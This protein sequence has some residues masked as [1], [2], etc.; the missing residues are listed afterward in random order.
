MNFIGLHSYNYYNEVHADVKVTQP[1]HKRRS[2]QPPPGPSLSRAGRAEPLIWQG[3]LA[4]VDA[5]G[6]VSVSYL[7]GQQPVSWTSTCISQ[8]GIE[9]VNGAGR[10]MN[11]ASSFFPEDCYPKQWQRITTQTMTE[12]AAIDNY[13][14]AATMLGRAFR[15]AR[16]RGVR[17]GV[18]NEVPA[19][20]PR[21]LPTTLA[22]LNAFKAPA[23]HFLTSGF[24]ACEYSTIC[25]WMCG[26]LTGGQRKACASDFQYVYEYGHHN[27]QSWLHTARVPHSIE[28]V[29]WYNGSTTTPGNTL[30]GTSGAVP[31]GYEG[32]NYSRVRH[33]GWIFPP[34]VT[35][36]MLP[37]GANLADMQP[38][39][40]WRQPSTTNRSNCA[41]SADNRT[42]TCVAD[43][44]WVHGKR[45]MPYT[46]WINE[47]TTTQDRCVTA[48]HTAG[49]AFAG[50][51]AGSACFCGDAIPMSKRLPWSSCEAVRCAGNT[52]QPCGAGNVLLVIPVVCRVVPVRT[53][54][55]GD[56]FATSSALLEQQA[57]A[58]GFTVPVATLGL[59]YS[60]RPFRWLQDMYQASFER[61]QRAMPSDLFWLW[62]QEIWNARA[63]TDPH[64][65]GINSS[66][67]TSVVE[68]FLA[69]DAAAKAMNA[70]FSLGT[71]GWTLGPME[72]RA[73]FDKV[74]PRDWT[75]TSIDE[76]LG[77]AGVE[78]AYAKVQNRSAEGGKWIIPWAEDGRFT[79][80]D[81][82]FVFLAG[83]FV[84]TTS[85]CA[86]SFADPH[87]GATQLWVNRTLQHMEVAKEM[88]VDGAL[89][90]TWRMETV[91]PTIWAL[92][93]KSWNASLS[94]ADAWAGWASGEFE[95]NRS[96]ALKVGAAFAALE[97]AEQSLHTVGCPGF[98]VQCTD[99]KIA[100]AYEAKVHAVADLAHF[101]PARSAGAQA[102]WRR[103][104][105][106]LRYVVA[107]T[108]AGCLAVGYPA[109][110][111]K[112][113][114]LPTAA[115][116]KV[117]AEQMLVPLRQEMVAAAHNITTLL[118]AAVA[119]PGEMG[120][121]STLH[122]IELLNQGGSDT[123]LR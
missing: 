47:P 5:S 45:A 26:A 67:V 82:Y 71:S 30:L 42:D 80:S 61:V 41:G 104:L 79:S 118:V 18:G 99:P 58:S 68:D 98:P 44:N 56:V 38:L 37:A 90:I 21:Q 25:T 9:Q 73:Y 6:N 60:K 111:A 114:E 17:V 34:N 20:P 113:R 46:A 70:S 29:T 108:E 54:F 12:A 59:V 2:A 93:H 84:L 78:A 7:D 51:E 72:D 86:Y 28:L 115:A 75:L 8:D 94:A 76:N 22:Y 117:A 64:V 77:H 87:L 83:V 49:F 23:D 91:G 52:S 116:R 106:F 33:E 100:V 1:A 66:A 101:V 10:Y 121:L 48:C 96:A 63:S 53:S 120:M 102:R 103:W 35:Q 109:A 97:G 85:C 24:Y 14:Y 65:G 16:K 15:H 13:N 36:A 123:D 4:A 11:G 110:A 3:P 112:V 95:L 122:D 105:S 43:A 107:S 89:L 74:L 31:T 57:A 69:A 27:V 119:G 81:L 50:V 55:E 88:S 92:S 32:H 62:T 40:L 19:M 39:R